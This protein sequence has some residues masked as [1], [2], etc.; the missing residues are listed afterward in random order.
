MIFGLL[1]DCLRSLFVQ[2]DFFDEFLVLLSDFLKYFG[3]V[4]EF[5]G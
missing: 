2:D 1:S 5:C 3:L 4:D